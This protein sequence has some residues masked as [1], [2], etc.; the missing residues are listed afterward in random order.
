M[1]RREISIL[2]ML[3]SGLVAGCEDRTPIK[4]EVCDQFQQGCLVV[5][6]FTDFESCRKYE[7]FNG[8]ICDYS[9]PGQFSCDTTHESISTS[10]C[11]N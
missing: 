5:A 10:H 8:A 2:L 4:Y 3:A 9:V 11:T 1:P 6:R 7:A